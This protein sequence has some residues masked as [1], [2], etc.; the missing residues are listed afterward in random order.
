MHII[1]EILNK[2]RKGAD[3]RINETVDKLLL[4]LRNRHTHQSWMTECY[5]EYCK[6][7]RKDYTHK[8]LELHHI[9]KQYNYLQCEYE[10]VGDESQT[11]ERL[12]SRIFFKEQELR[13]LKQFKNLLK[14]Q[15]I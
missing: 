14:T 11:T 15:I 6:F 4:I 12:N 9:K 1:N 2:V 8:K 7:I 10:F 5:C 3:L 13:E